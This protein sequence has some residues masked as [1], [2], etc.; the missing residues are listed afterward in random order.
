[1]R[2]ITCYLRDGD[3][4]PYSF[5]Y[6]IDILYFHPPPPSPHKSYIDSTPALLQM[7]ELGAH[8]QA[9]AQARRELEATKENT[10]NCEN[11]LEAI[12]EKLSRNEDR[13]RYLFT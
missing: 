1:M 11:E 5:V 10:E 6:L 7:M 3:R 2:I 12:G 8:Q 9:A 4:N 13:V